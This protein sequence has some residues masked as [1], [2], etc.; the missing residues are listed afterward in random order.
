[1]TTVAARPTVSEKVA[2]KTNWKARIVVGLPLY[3]GMVYLATQKP[4]LFLWAIGMLVF[5]MT[6][7]LATIAIRTRAS[8]PLWLATAATAIATPYCFWYLSSFDPVLA[9]LSI[10]LAGGADVGSMVVGKRWGK[11]FLPEWVNDHKTY[12]GVAGGWFLA[13]IFGLLTWVGIQVVDA[14]PR[15]LFKEALALSLLVPAAAF[16]G[17]LTGSME[18]RRAAVG[19]SCELLP[20][21]D[22]VSRSGHGGFLDRVGS[23]T[24]TVC[25]L[26][27]LV[28]AFEVIR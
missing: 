21:M 24:W 25:L 14:V 1:M 17:D 19:D 8:S 11:T 13:F 23:H 9:V 2:K 28:W 5:L 3:A 26:A 20:G 22:F 6:L 15:F 4:N 16:L 7:E 10:N 12:E 27:F 18:K